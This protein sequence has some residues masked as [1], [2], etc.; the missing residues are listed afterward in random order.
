LAIWLLAVGGMGNL[1]PRLIWSGVWDYIHVP[2]LPFWFNL[3]DVLIVIGVISY[4]LG[5]DG[6]CCFVRGQRDTGNK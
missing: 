6:N 4:I 3:S 2:I 5:V 1:V